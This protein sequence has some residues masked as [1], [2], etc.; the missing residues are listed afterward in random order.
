MIDAVRVLRFTYIQT[1]K[2]TEASIL[3]E[4]KKIV[5][6]R[7][8]GAKIYLYGSRVKGMPGKYSDWDIVI[9]LNKETISRQLEKEITYPLYDLEIETGEIISPTVYTQTEWHTRHKATPFYR[10]VMNEGRLL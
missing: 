1:M 4:I 9:L 3:S 5:R 6:E 7:D 10:S 2:Y 8:P